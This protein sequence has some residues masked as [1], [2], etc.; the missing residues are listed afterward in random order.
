MEASLTSDVGTDSSVAVMLSPAHEGSVAVMFGPAQA[1]EIARKMRDELARECGE[2]L[3]APLPN[4]T[5]IARLQTIIEI[6]AEQLEGLEWGEPRADVEML[7][8][9]ELLGTIAPALSDGREERIRYEALPVSAIL[10]HL[11][12]Q[13]DTD[14]RLR[15]TLTPLDL[16]SRT[17][18]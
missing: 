2:A 9:A 12:D 1:N 7:C 6:Y 14:P 18:V 3:A 4:H 16:A 11:I 10:A 13:I 8:D 5:R 15:P 17:E